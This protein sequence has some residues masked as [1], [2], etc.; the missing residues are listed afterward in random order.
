MTGSEIDLSDYINNLDQVDIRYISKLN[1]DSNLFK[2]T[3]KRGP[4]TVIVV[5]YKDQGCG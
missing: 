4:Q 3:N 5:E 2:H 1:L